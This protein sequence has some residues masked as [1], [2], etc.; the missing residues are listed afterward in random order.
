MQLVASVSECS[1]VHQP[2]AAMGC[3]LGQVSVGKKKNLIIPNSIEFAHH[4]IPCYP[5]AEMQNKRDLG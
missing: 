5:E 4:L 3:L 1:G 2:G